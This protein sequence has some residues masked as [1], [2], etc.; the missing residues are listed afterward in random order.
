MMVGVL[1]Y[2]SDV[3]CVCRC[4]RRRCEVGGRGGW[5]RCGGV[6]RPIST[7]SNSLILRGHTP[8]LP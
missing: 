6:M 4:V 7:P 8:Q 3:W 1:V 2:W 5:G